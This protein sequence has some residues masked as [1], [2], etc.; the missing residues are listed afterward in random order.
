MNTQQNI[1]I[2]VVGCGNMGASH[3]MAY[4]NI[5][6]SFGY[7]ENCTA[8]IELRGQAEISEVI[9]KHAGA[10][11]G[12]GAHTAFIQMTAEALGVTPNI[13]TLIASDTA[14]TG[15]SGSVSAS[16]MTFMAGNA[17]KGA[18]ARALDKWMNEERPAVAVYTYLA[19][20]TTPYDP[21]TGRSEPN[22]A[23]GY[24]AAAAEVEVDIE[25]GELEI[26]K[27]FC[28]KISIIKTTSSPYT[29]PKL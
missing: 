22:V 23:Y 16:R 10:E 7:Q 14:V 20:K 4:K 2:L 25:T 11:V 26:K 1:R 21:Q 15:N 29:I 3:A 6:F 5:G 27:I 17:I 28:S 9:L 8:E 19:P 24:V 13:I 18:A 12:Q